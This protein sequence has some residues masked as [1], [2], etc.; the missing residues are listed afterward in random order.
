MTLDA[1]RDGMQQARAAARAYLRHQFCSSRVN[2]EH[3]IAIHLH[4]CNVQAQSTRRSARAGGHRSAGRRCAPAVVLTD[5][6]HWQLI[7]PGPVESL[8]KRTAVDRAVTKK[9]GCDALASL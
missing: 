1:V 3:I 5:E 4:G 9:T 2:R 6:Q 8:Q 7:D